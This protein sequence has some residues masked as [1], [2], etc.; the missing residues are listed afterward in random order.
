MNYAITEPRSIVLDSTTHALLDEVASAVADINRS[1]P[2]PADLDAKL[3][4][5]LLPDRVTASLNMEGITASRRQT[6]AMMDAMRVKESA[7]AGE[8]EVYNALRAD[9]FIA[10]AVD[11]GVPF[12]EG[13]VR[14]INK[15]LIEELRSDAGVWRPGD[16]TL[17]GAK[18]V[19]PPGPSVPGMMSV[20]SDLFPLS[21][22][23]H[24]VVQAAWLHDQFTYVHPFN[25]GNGRTGRLLQDWSLIRRGYWPTGIANSK[26]D[27]Y[28]SA[29]ERADKGSW[30]DLVELIALLQL[31]IVS[32]VRAVLDEAR[33]RTEW[34]ARL[35]S[36]ATTKR[37]NARHK[38]YIVWRKRV[39]AVS[40]A[41]RQAALEIDASSTAIG[42]TFRDYSVIDFREWDNVCRRGVG[43][44]TWLFSVIFFIDGKP[45][46]KSIAYLKRHVALPNVDT[47]SPLQDKVA[48]YF[49]G[50]DLP[51]TER[52]PF[53]HY[54]DPHIRLREVL[55][56]DDAF[57][58][59]EELPDRSGWGLTT[60]QTIGAAVE[61]FFVDLF[62]R[63]AG[64]AS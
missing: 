25:D 9:E 34:V 5:S 19:P 60:S 51:E 1:R 17:L 44:R 55:P 6:L 48:I 43:D 63:K 20:L 32:K 23:L 4:Q 8:R 7:G 13:L 27:D 21:E 31:D 45:F 59:Y 26:R 15:L 50:V 54:D 53:H 37:D 36:A 33:S 2:L 49:T 16:V 18:H 40:A 47:F 28:Y 12:S 52:A 14:E 29:L 30:D 57:F 11:R 24:P 62:E 35:A 56:M 46:Y 10:D 64:L 22:S 38:Q 41:F 42:A 3:R 39:E 61:R 58:V